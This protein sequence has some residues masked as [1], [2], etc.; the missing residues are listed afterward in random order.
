MP[1]SGR[2]RRG[3][4]EPGIDEETMNRFGYALL[5]DKKAKDAVDISS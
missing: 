1:G 2:L 3:T 4:S 5:R